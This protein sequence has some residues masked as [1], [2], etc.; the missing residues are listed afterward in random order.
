MLRILMLMFVVITACVSPVLAAGKRVALVMGNASY[1]DVGALANP[2][3]DATAVAAALEATGFDTVRHVTDLSAETMRR[4][5]K[6]FSARAASAEVAIVY[7]AG[8]GVEV[9]EQN[10]LVP[11]DAKLLRSTDIDFEAISLASVRS[12]VSGA[13]KLRVV[14][15]DACRNNPFTLA[16]S[17]GT[18]AATRG[19]GRIEPS[20]GEVV[21]YAAKEGTLA[22][23]GPSN[24]NSPFAEALVKSLK[25]PGLEIRLLFGRVRDDVLS[26][27]ANEQEPYTY[28]SLGGE[29]VYINPPRTNADSA[30]AQE[31]QLVAA[32]NSATVLQAFRDKY[33]NDPV[34]RALAEE[35]LAFLQKPPSSGAQDFADCDDCPKMVVVPKGRFVMGSPGDEP[36]REKD[37]GPQRD[38]NIIRNFAVSKFEITFQQ[39]NAFVQATG[40]DPGKSCLIFDGTRFKVRTGAD[41]SNPGFVQTGRHPVTCVSWQDAR[42]YA[43]WLSRKTGFKYRLLTEA[44]WE[45]AA[46]AGVTSAF[47]AGDVLGPKDANFNS[48]A[49]QPAGHFA[50]NGFGLHDMQGNVWEWTEDCHFPDYFAA[51]GCE[52]SYR[53]GAWA[54]ISRDVRFAARGTN[55]AN[56]RVNIFGIRVARDLP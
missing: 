20:A 22:Q 2:K 15:L 34:Y 55:R 45:Y 42:A 21:A 31:W 36:G 7:Y 48:S 44:E 14:V 54:N 12:A 41:F 19:L 27:T 6:D 23:D 38:V 9:A 46:R 50:A 17:G 24:S 47:M 18:R 1:A 43:V 37:E 26:A 3:A 4:E 28:A 8:H 49:T 13:S 40:H 33:H 10:Y 5:L 29:A 16:G 52:R 11:V 35:R 25:E 51:P 53:G 39:Y 32:S 56:M 30:A